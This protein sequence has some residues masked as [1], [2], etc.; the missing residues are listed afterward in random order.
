MGYC[1]F[2]NA[3]VYIVSLSVVGVP[4]S[5]GLIKTYLPFSNSM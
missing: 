2:K 4:V 3:E 5:Q 1:H